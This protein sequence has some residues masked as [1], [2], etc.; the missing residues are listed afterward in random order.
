MA[1]NIRHAFQLIHTQNPNLKV[2]NGHYLYNKTSTPQITLNL[3]SCW[4]WF[5]NSENILCVY[6]RWTEFLWPNHPT[7]WCV[8]KFHIWIQV[9]SLQTEPI[10]VWK[11]NMASLTS[12]LPASPVQQQNTISFSIER[13]RSKADMPCT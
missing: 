1:Q 10:F 8:L 11:N 13:L 2:I 5:P 3:G 4:N 7:F 9:G 12:W 6:N